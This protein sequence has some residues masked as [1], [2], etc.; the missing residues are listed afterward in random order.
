[1]NTKSNALLVLEDGRYFKGWQFGATGETYG[2]VCFNTG[3]CGYQ[4]I[5]TDPSYC[6]QIVT[7]TTPQVG[8]YGVN[9]EDPES[10]K[11]QVAGFVIREETD[12][13][14]NW[15]SQQSIG[16]Y[17]RA[18]NIVG[19]QGLDTRALTRHLRDQG[20]MNGIISTLELD[21]EK[22]LPK[23]K[24]L[25]AMA[26]QDLAKEVTCA[27]MIDWYGNQ[28][29]RLIVVI[30]FGVKTSILR[31]LKDS[32]F[33]I[34]I[35]PAQTSASEIL[36][37][38]PAGVL[39]SN[40]P[41]DPEPVT[42]GIDTVKQ[43]L[44]KVPIFGICLGHQILALALGAKTYKLKFGHRGINHPV[45]NLATG[46][47]NIT[48]QNHGFAVDADSLPD[49]V[50]ITHSS[51]NDHTVEGINCRDYPAF[52]VQYHPEAGPGPHDAAYVFREFI[53]LIEEQKGGTGNA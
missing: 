8:N 30:D 33:R 4:E 5:L 32:G 23:V 46:Q 36:G 22:L 17:L 28:T 7:L 27:E 2:E 31:S 43:L 48:S 39:L 26:G 9:S 14:S 21:P 42:Y 19:I 50:D 6:R 40:G 10:S 52:S 47:V 29:D 37:M 49:S 41:G 25:P 13:P 44:G 15:R 1:M 20:A 34:R 53:D 12:Q 38:R 11:I 18:Q 3:F 24:A 51:L 45:Q 16:D 35:V